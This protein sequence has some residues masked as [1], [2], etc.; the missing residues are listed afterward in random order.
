VI[1][2]SSDLQT[3]GDVI[4]TLPS[5]VDSTGALKSLQVQLGSA[6]TFASFDLQSKSIT[7]SSEKAL[8]SSSGIYKVDVVLEDEFGAISTSSFEIQLI[9]ETQTP[10]VKPQPVGTQPFAENVMIIDDKEYK[11]SESD[12]KNSDALKPP[13]FPEPEARPLRGTISQVAMDGTFS[14]TWSD[15]IHAVNLDSLISKNIMQVRT[16]WTNSDIVL[17]R[18]PA[19]TYQ[20]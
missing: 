6:G 15:K 10:I 17:E 4:I 11:V 12:F 8:A 14:I 20:V 3:K 1:L 13:F 5:I 7:I 19:P 9:L 16:I 18:E 2:T